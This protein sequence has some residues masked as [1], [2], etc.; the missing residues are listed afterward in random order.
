M[1]Y[2]YDPRVAQWSPWHGA[3]I[4]VLSSLAKIGAL[5]GNPAGCSLTFQEYFERAS[6]PE[7][8]GK[9]TA[10]LLGALEAQKATK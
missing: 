6:S 3:Q 8:W 10:A 9:P 1:S 4:A 7:A 5:G 2:G